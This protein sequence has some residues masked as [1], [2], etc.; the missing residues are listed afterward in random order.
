MEKYQTIVWFMHKPQK[1]KIQIIGIRL[2]LPGNTSNTERGLGAIVFCC[3]VTSL[4][5]NTQRQ[6]T[7][8]F[9]TVHS[10]VVRWYA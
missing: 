10:F 7:P 5:G 4:A 9:Q 6:K 8:E 3:L 1:K 2:D